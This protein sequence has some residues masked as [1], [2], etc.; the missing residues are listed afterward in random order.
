MRASDTGNR[1][2]QCPVPRCPTRRSSE[3]TLAGHLIDVHAYRP[4]Q[5]AVVAGIAHRLARG[6]TPLR[7]HRLT[8]DLP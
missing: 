8:E 6:P 2:L 5:A 7:T 4:D 1:I 3:I